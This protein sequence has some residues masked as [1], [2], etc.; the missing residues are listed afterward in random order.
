MK[1]TLNKESEYI[2]E[3]NDNRN[4]ED[5]IKFHLRD[6]TTAERD[7]YVKFKLVEGKEPKTEADFQMIFSKC[8][9]KIDNL[10]V[11]GEKIDSARKLLNTAGLW[12][13]FMEVATYISAHNMAATSKN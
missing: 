3:W 12:P 5:P 13:L 10:E 11:D 7:S 2:P 4:D 6:L 1:V 8:V 9:K